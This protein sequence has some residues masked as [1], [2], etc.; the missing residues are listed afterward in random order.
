MLQITRAHGAIGS[1][2]AKFQKHLPSKALVRPRPGI[3]FL[4]HVLFTVSELAGTD[5]T[6]LLYSTQVVPRAAAAVLQ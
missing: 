3:V 5:C 2:Q 1:V 6:L 4:H